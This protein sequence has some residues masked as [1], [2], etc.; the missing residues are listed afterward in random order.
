[1]KQRYHKYTEWEDYKNGMYDSSN[2]RLE[3]VELSKNLLSNPKEFKR[4]GVEMFR[5]WLKASQNHLTNKNSNRRSWIGQA[6]CSYKH[7]STESE[8]RKAWNELETNTKIKANLIAD[9][10]I[11]QYEAEYYKLYKD[12]GEKM[13][14]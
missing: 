9:E 12:L 1:M 7:N 3:F 4:I 10:I 14:F 11:K 6:A 2:I 5:D 13:L 8:T